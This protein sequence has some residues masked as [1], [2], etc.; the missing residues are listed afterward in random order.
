MSRYLLLPARAEEA[1]HAIRRE[2][3]R[4]RPTAR[5]DAL[6]F[7]AF[8]ET[9]MQEVRY[10][11]PAEQ[12]ARLEGGEPMLRREWRLFLQDLV[13]PGADVEVVHPESV[14]TASFAPGNI[15][16]YLA[17]RGGETP[18]HLEVDGAATSSPAG[19]LERS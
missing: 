1:M 6:R 15:H 7:E 4:G 9:A 13:G 18:A 17:V 19:L 10:A 5:V 12:R 11:M 16:Q 14:D 3:P 2:F 8:V